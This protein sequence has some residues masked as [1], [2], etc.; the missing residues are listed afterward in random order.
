MATIFISCFIIRTWKVNF[1]ASLSLLKSFFVCKVGNKMADKM[2]ASVILKIIVIL[3]GFLQYFK[4][5]FYVRLYGHSS[6]WHFTIY[7]LPAC[8]KNIL[9][10]NTVAL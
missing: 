1:G 6:S 4:K 3:S 8:S 7:H 5:P 9:Q 10:P 2:C